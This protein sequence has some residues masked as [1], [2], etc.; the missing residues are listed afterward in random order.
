MAAILEDIHTTLLNEDD[1]NFIV[2]PSSNTIYSLGRNGELK[3]HPFAPVAAC[4]KPA[5]TKKNFWKRLF[6]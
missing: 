4:P 1:T 5:T 2:D 6:H 3:S